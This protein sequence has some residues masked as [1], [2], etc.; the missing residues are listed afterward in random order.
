[1]GIMREV[2][3]SFTMHFTLKSWNSINTNLLNN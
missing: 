3:P 1:M 2:I